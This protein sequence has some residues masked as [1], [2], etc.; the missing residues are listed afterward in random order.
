MEGLKYKELPLESSE[1]NPVFTV[2]DLMKMMMEMEYKIFGYNEFEI[3]DEE[4]TYSHSI[5]YIP[6]YITRV[7]ISGGCIEYNYGNY[8]NNTNEFIIISTERVCSTSSELIYS[9]EAPPEGGGSGPID[10]DEECKR[11]FVGIK[12]FDENGN[13]IIPCL[14]HDLVDS[15]GYYHSAIEELNNYLELNPYGLL[16]CDE[17]EK[18]G[19]FGLM[20]QDVGSFRLPQLLKNR[21]DSINNLFPFGSNNPLAIYQQTL[22]NANGTVV[23]C[24]FYPIVINSLPTGF[25]AKSLLEYFRI[26]INSFSEPECRFDPY[27]F[28]FFSNS[29]SDTSRWNSSFDASVGAIV[30]IDIPNEGSVILSQYKNQI[31]INNNYENHNFMFSTLNSP[32]DFSHPVAGNREFGIYNTA[33][34]P[35]RHFFYTMGVDRVNNRYLIPIQNH[36]F[37]AGGVLWTNVQRKFITF[38]NQNGGS[39]DLGNPVNIE[40]R[41]KYILVEKFLRKEMSLDSLKSILGC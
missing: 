28:S 40:A 34:N 15:S 31:G 38:I 6:S 12:D 25:T 16:P 39:A 3:I 37:D 35:N 8:D 7:S 18:I 5:G 22:E 10:D 32:L 13:P 9:I 17:L 41:P 14:H 30:H 20:F 21:I 26:N 29:V 4:V 27:S 19:P 11:G 23:N 33:D 2:M 36:V 1:S 24:D